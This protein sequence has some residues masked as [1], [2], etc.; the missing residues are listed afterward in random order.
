MTGTP[1]VLLIRHGRSTHIQSGWISREQFLRWREAYESAGIRSDDQPPQALRDRVANAHM[2][3][4]DARRA[5]ESAQALAPGCEIVASP[6]FRELDLHPPH[7]GTLRLPMIGWGLMYGLRSLV[8]SMLRRPHLSPGESERVETAADLI[9]EVAGSND[10]VAI[11]TH[12]SFRAELA[13]RLVARGWQNE[14]HGRLRHWS[15]WT[16]T[17]TIP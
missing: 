5:V 4:S 6:L 9:E 1:R 14:V 13:R 17:R 11:I 2:I 8:R 16:L 12:A 7:L 10:A 3:A 15:A